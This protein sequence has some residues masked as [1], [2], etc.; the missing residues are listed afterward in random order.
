MN[1]LYT[2]LIV[3]SVCPGIGFVGYGIGVVAQASGVG[4]SRMLRSR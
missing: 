3:A 2:A 1:E 4:I